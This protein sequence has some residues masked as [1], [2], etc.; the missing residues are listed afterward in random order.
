[1]TPPI[2]IFATSLLALFALGCA[3]P[4]ARTPSG[5][6]ES[7]SPVLSGG[8]DAKCQTSG[9]TAGT[10][11]ISAS[12]LSTSNCSVE[13]AGGNSSDS[14]GALIATTAASTSAGPVATTYFKTSYPKPPLCLIA[15]NGKASGDLLDMAGLYVST[16]TSSYFQVTASSAA[17][18]NT[19]GG[20]FNWICVG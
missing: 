10:V 19:P 9:T 4:V 13:S 6:T 15:V 16:V 11:V 3:S 18:A 12:Y 8:F 14:R 1:M 7:P 20:G 2:R 5:T 17:A